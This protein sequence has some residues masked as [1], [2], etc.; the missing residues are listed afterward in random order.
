LSLNGVRK[1]SKN[2]NTKFV[3]ALLSSVN[4]QKSNVAAFNQ[5]AAEE[6]LKNE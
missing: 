2:G 3:N 5:A 6:F 4:N 1:K